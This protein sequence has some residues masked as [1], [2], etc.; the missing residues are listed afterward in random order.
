MN[1]VRLDSNP[2]PDPDEFT[3]DHM[4]QS[5]VSEP[6]EDAVLPT[7]RYSFPN[8]G[9]GE[10]R[11]SHFAVDITWIDIKHLVGEFI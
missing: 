8:F 11:R 6:L 7:V 2:H 1:L 5:F 10:H 3:H 9:R 4:Q